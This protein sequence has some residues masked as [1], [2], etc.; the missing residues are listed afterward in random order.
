MLCFS[1]N[2]Q[3]DDS[4]IAAIPCLSIPAPILA[5]GDAACEAWLASADVFEGR[6]DTVHYRF[7]DETLFGVIEVDEVSQTD[8]HT[9][10]LQSATE[11]AYRQIFTLLDELECPFIYRFWNYMADIN[12]FSHGLERYRQFNTGRQNA[13]IASGR[14]VTGQ[15]PAACALGI[16]KGKLKIA[17]IAGRMPARAIENPRQA[18]AY[19]YPQQYGPSSPTFS[20][21]SLL[22]LKQG[23]ILL[24]SGTASVV[25]HQTLHAG[26]V[27]AQARETLSNLES[28]IAEANRQMSQPKFTLKDA[29]CRVYLR[30]AADLPVVRSEIEQVLGPDV[31]A[32]FIQADICREDLLLEI[33]ATILPT[34]AGIGG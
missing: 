24:I 12:G 29:F 8:A 18:N 22:S 4:R 15:L 5:S 25:G 7:D 13:F 14:Q 16:A 1:N 26:N 17:F 34:S 32:I 23:G 27:I 6:R 9:A 21:A 33:E 30:H 31:K 2:T 3:I 11:S 10:P 28:V 20:R 19:D